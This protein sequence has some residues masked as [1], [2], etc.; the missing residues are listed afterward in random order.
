MA[1][2]RKETRHGLGFTMYEALWKD[3]FTESP[4][5]A[6]WMQRSKENDI[7][8]KDIVNKAV[9]NA[10]D[11]SGLGQGLPPLHLDTDCTHG[12]TELSPSQSVEQC[13]HVLKSNL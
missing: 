12:P 9:A 4:R 10:L 13:L 6:S 3:C 11:K 8:I 5:L 1:F 7:D 2:G